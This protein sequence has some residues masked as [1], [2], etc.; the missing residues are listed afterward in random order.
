MTQNYMLETENEKVEKILEAIEE[1]RNI[2][3]VIDKNDLELFRNLEFYETVITNEDIENGYQKYLKGAKVTIMYKNNDNEK[4]IAT[5]I[6]EKLKHYVYAKKMFLISNIEEIDIIQEIGKKPWEY[7]QWI[8]RDMLT[9]SNRVREKIIEGKLAYS[10]SKTINYCLIGEDGD[11]QRQIYIYNNGVY[12]EIS[13]CALKSYVKE[14]IPI[15]LHTDKILTCVTNLLISSKAKDYSILTGEEDII[16]LKNGLYNVKTGKL[17][18]HR[19]EYICGNQLNVKFNE[20]YT[21]SGYW[22]KYIDDLTM[23]DVELKNILQEW[24][25][26]TLSNYN[27]AMAKKMLILYGERDTGKSKFIN[28]LEDILVDSVE[29]I[30]IEDLGNKF[31]LGNVRGKRL[32]YSGE[33]ASIEIDAEAAET[34]KMLTGG[35]TVSTEKKFQDHKG[36]KFRGVLTY[37]GNHV[38]L[39]KGNNFEECF[40]RIIIIP[41][42]NII[43]DNKKDPNIFSKILKDKEYIFNWGLIGLNRLIQNKFKFS[44]AKKAEDALNEYKKKVDSVGYYIDKKFI[45][46]GNRKD[47]I[48]SSELY[49]VY[50]TWCESSLDKPVNRLEF[51]NRL[52]KKG[53]LYNEKYQGNPYYEGVILKE[54]EK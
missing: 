1:E 32:I 26:L 10:I 44:Y 52:C 27:G 16:N 37:S 39:M 6:K 18:K 51:K 46:T 14:Y 50:L 31:A 22:D 11:K 28:F 42:K 36:T 43:T 13:F 25:G 23:G 7:A 8:Q 4:L 49:K 9:N 29:A 40:N 19:I 24:L 15:H 20:K 33:I 30:K 54:N 17:E 12:K 48:K 41:C 5:E 38:P 53:V 47:R 45:I 3:I 35:D 34:M 21:N 2:Y